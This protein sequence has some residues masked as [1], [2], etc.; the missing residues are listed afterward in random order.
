MNAGIRRGSWYKKSKDIIILVSL[1]TSQQPYDHNYND[2][3]IKLYMYLID[4]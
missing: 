1:K 3:K 4:V 2:E